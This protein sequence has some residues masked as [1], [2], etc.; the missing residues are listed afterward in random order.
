MKPSETS[1][2]EYAQMKAELDSLK[3]LVSENMNLNENAMRHAMK[4]K[5]DEMNRSAMRIIALSLVTMCCMP[6]ILLRFCHASTVFII[7]SE[8]M[9]LFCILATLLMHMPVRQLNFAYDSLVEVANR[10]S[11]FRQQYVRWPLIGIP[12]VILWL[13]WLMLEL[14][15][16]MEYDRTSV[17]FTGAGVLCGAVL[18]GFIGM[19]LNRH[20]IRKA[21]EV[22]EEIHRLKAGI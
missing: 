5:A 15:S 6:S 22:L 19:N 9:M 14:Y 8:A 4:G 10:M 7:A 2:T 16:G 18:G 12:M 11:R 20:V 17:L 13:A 1:E 3:R 21:D